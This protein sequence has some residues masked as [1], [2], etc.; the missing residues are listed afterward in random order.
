MKHANVVAE[1]WGYASLS[2]ADEQSA[3]ETNAQLK[4]EL[5][6][7]WELLRSTVGSMREDYQARVQALQEE[8]ERRGQSLR[9]LQKHLEVRQSAYAA[10]SNKIMVMATDSEASGSAMTS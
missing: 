1:L 10:L 4:R 6:R 2:E 9:Q 8:N 7:A 5:E 3:Q